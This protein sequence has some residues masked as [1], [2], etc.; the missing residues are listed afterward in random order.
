M[1]TRSVFLTRKSVC[2]L[3]ESK[4]WHGHKNC[5]ARSGLSKLGGTEESRFAKCEVIEDKIKELVVLLGLRLIL[6]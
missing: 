5:F 4:G 3:D 2:L 1:G 6:L